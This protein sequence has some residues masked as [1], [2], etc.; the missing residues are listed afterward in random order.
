M[1]HLGSI[2]RENVGFAVVLC[3]I[4][5]AHE[6]SDTAKSRF[7]DNFVDYK[8]FFTEPRFKTHSDIIVLI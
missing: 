2:I 1:L 8:L 7:D 6:R 5:I 4:G 3:G